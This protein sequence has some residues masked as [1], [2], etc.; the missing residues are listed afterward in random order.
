MIGNTTNMVM[1]NVSTVAR[2]PRERAQTLNEAK[3]MEQYLRC[4]RGIYKPPAT[5]KVLQYEWTENAVEDTG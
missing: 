3:K 4:F 5:P 1:A 2:P